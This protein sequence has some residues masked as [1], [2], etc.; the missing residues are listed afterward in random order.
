VSGGRTA[1]IAT[2]TGETILCLSSID[3]DFNWQGHQEIMS[4]LAGQGN[5]VLF[6]ENTGV[7][8]PTIRDLARLRQRVRNWWRDARTGRS[9]RPGL[10]V[11]APLLL[12]F[13]YSR[14]ALGLNRRI[15]M[16]TVR[17]WLRDARCSH[18][19][20]WT[21]LP[22]RLSN[23]VIRE[24]A[25]ELTVYYCVDDF[26]GSSRPAQRVAPSEAALFGSADMVFV[27]TETLRQRALR[28]RAEA[29]VF[30]FGVN[31]AEF[32]RVRRSEPRAPADVAGLARPRIG[33]VGGVNRKMDQTLVADVATRVPEA[34][35]VFV[36]PLEDDARVLRACRNVHLL[37]ARPHRDVPQYLRAFDV[38]IIPYRRTRYTEHVYPAK[39][40]EYL[41]MGLPVVA[42][43]LEQLHRV[44]A[45]H[46]PVVRI[47]DDAGTFA[48]AIREALVDSPPAETARRIDVAR[49]N[50][51]E[52]RVAEML[53]LVAAELARRRRAAAGSAGVHP[54]APRP[55]GS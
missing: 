15:L 23:H 14:L 10:A 43:G 8:A 52:V 53:R 30:P 51:W 36:G 6:V 48:A 9:D 35:F 11:H 45:R 37:G 1:K 3:W 19:I 42:T 41:A 20:V 33:F 50:S 49:E 16:R 5:R 28:F 31:F 38:A 2:L 18:P 27:T 40:N 13:P 12:P 22:T 44:N 29:H 47:A 4:R 26:P 7:R 39:L 46:G 25:P 54:L 21:F 55:A 32:E 34:S 17:R 24:V